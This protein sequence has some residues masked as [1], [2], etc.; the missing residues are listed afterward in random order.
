M[1][2]VCL[3]SSSF[4]TVSQRYGKVCDLMWMWI[5]LFLAVLPEEIEIE[6]MT[7]TPFFLFVLKN[8]KWAFTSAYKSVCVLNQSLMSNS[9][10]SMDCSPLGSSVHGLSEARILECVTIFSSRVSSWFRD[11][12]CIFSI[13]FIGRWILL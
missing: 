11:W 2:E 9:C 13:S 6:I 5:S 12:V 4:P 3:F 8:K 7:D 1:E 10:H